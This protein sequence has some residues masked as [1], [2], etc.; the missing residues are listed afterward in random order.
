MG[1]CV[2]ADVAEL[3]QVSWK[4]LSQI[5]C[6]ISESY[7]VVRQLRVECVFGDLTGGNFR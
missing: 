6:D 2:I 5:R 7:C 3:G 4:L 1:V